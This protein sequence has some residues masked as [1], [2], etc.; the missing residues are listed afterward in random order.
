MIDKGLLLSFSEFHEYATAA[1][2][3]D[4]HGMRSPDEERRD[5]HHNPLHSGYRLLALEKLHQVRDID[6]HRTHRG[7]FRQ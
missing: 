6:E 4:A 2:Q 3:E 7:R 1:V 5:L